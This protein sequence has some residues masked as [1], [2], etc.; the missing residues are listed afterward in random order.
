MANKILLSFC[1]VD[2]LF[3]LGGVLLL[4]GGLVM[5]MVGTEA[6]NVDNVARALLLTMFPTKGAFILDD[7]EEELVKKEK[8]EGL[9]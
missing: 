4:V 6:K 2:L 7:D 5:H 8:E 9:Q 3:L 1:F